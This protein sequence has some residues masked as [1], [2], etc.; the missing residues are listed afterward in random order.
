MFSAQHQQRIERC[1]PLRTQVV[2][3]NTNDTTGT[4]AEH[5]SK[6]N[7]A[8]RRKNTTAAQRTRTTSAHSKRTKVTEQ[9]QQTTTKTEYITRGVVERGEDGGREAADLGVANHRRDLGE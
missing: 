3:S 5:S 4:N 8:G 9:K 2:N 1:D 7:K 6:Q